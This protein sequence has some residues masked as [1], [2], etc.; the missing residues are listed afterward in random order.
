LCQT[1]FWYCTVLYFKHNG[2]SSTKIILRCVYN[3]VFIKKNGHLHLSVFLLTLFNFHTLAS[4]HAI[5]L[6]SLLDLHS[7]CNILPQVYLKI[8]VR[9]TFL[10]KFM[11]CPK[12]FFP[13]DS[14][15]LTYSHY[16]IL[17]RI[18][19]CPSCKQNH[20]L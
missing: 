8:Y 19:Y 7:I 10:A 3:N 4:S 12:V 20:F 13:P 16:R 2:M 9:L 18:L 1:S 17:R 15:V 11:R 5:T 14:S 6:L